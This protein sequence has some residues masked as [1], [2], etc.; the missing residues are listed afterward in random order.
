[1]PGF[2]VALNSTANALSAIQQALDAVQNNTVN[3]ST[4]GY[5]SQN[6]TFSAQAFDPGHGLTGG[7]EV[8]LSSSRNQYLEQSV[9][10]ETSTLGLFEQQSPLLTSLQNAFDTSGNAGIPGALSSFADSFSTLSAS[11]NDPSAQANAIQAAATVAQ[12]FNQTAAQIQ[13]VADQA[14]GQASMAVT[15]INALVRHIA[16]VNAAI[17]N[18]SQKDAGAAAD[19]N[20]SLDSLSELVNISVTNN[21]D[22]SASVLLDGQTPLVLGSQAYAL[23][24]L[25]HAGSSAAAYPGGDAGLQ[26]LSQD[27]TDVT[28]QAT[29]GKLGAALQ[30]RNQTVPYYLGSQSQQGVLNTLAYSFASRV[31]AIVTAGQLAAGSTVAPVFDVS[32]DT[33]AAS[34]L[35]VTSITPSELVAS[36]GTAGNGVATELADITNPTNPLDLMSGGQSFTAYYGTFSGKA[37]LDASESATNLTTQQDLTTQAQNQ[38][39]QASGVSLNAQAAQLL[40]LQQAY[41]AT[42]R[43]VT[44]LE[45]LSQTVVNLIPQS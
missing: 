24:I 7:V 37:G 6:V 20:N 14:T 35:A 45:S 32:N 38:R 15:Q 10:T 36:D 33:S 17:Q 18:G 29:Q 43:I 4:P 1:M 42:A 25:P 2:S 19:L 34:T 31:N 27:G 13:Q 40:S 9:R 12:A 44:V 3:A 41:Q 23:T 30:V 11:P 28:A 8:S 22:G 5:A 16:A 21:A 26:L 39:T